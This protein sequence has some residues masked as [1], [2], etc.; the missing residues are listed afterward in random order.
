MEVIE[1]VDCYTFPFCLA[2]AVREQNYIT[3]CRSIEYK[4]EFSL[5]RSMFARTQ[6]TTVILAAKSTVSN[7]DER[8]GPRFQ[9]PFLG[10]VMNHVS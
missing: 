8:T 4:R 1:R 3:H 10:L 6:A 9:V 7:L 2:S 5:M